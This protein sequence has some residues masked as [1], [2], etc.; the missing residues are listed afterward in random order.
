MLLETGD[1]EAT[2]ALAAKR[3]G[4]AVVQATAPSVA[5]GAGAVPASARFYVLANLLPALLRPDPRR[6]HGNGVNGYITTTAANTLTIHAMQ[7][8]LVGPIR[9]IRSATAT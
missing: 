2:A 6:P 7:R 4:S 3:P 8:G 9:P 1:R 5:L